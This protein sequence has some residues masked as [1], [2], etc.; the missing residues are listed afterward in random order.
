MQVIYVDNCY[1]V[2]EKLEYIDFQT[3][4]KKGKKAEINQKRNQKKTNN[5]KQKT[6]KDKEI[7]Q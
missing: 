1:S 5:K 7:I 2:S 4:D 6:N 3:H